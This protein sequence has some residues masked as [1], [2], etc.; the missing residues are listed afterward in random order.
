MENLMG[1][2]AGECDDMPCTGTQAAGAGL[3]CPVQHTALASKLESHVV[4]GARTALARV[5]PDTALA[6][7]SLYAAAE[8][9]NSTQRVT[10]HMYRWEQQARVG[11]LLTAVGTAQ[12]IAGEVLFF[13]E[14]DGLEFAVLL[15]MPTLEHGHASF[16]VDD[17]STSV[18]ALP[19]TGLV[20][21]HCSY[22]STIGGQRHATTSDSL[23]L[24][25]VPASYLAGIQ[26][27][28]AADTAAAA[29]AL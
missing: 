24:G 9:D 15:H 5:C 23:P 25:M 12:S 18:V 13:A 10:S 11:V 26:A 8:V 1:G 14:A 27:Q 21:D 22:T 19:C 28:H 3:V 6:D 29:A 20:F 16:T 17:H 4:D 7:M 2:G